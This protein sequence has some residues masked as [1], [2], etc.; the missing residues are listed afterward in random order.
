MST[1]FTTIKVVLR[2][3]G[4][5]AGDV[6]INP[7]MVT[8]MYLRF[9]LTKKGN[10]QKHIRIEFVKWIPHEGGYTLIPNQRAESLQ[11][12]AK[13]KIG[14]LHVGGYLS[15]EEIA[16]ETGL[17]LVRLQRD[18]ELTYRVLHAHNW[19]EDRKAPS[20]VMQR[21]LGLNNYRRGHQDEEE[22]MELNES[23]QSDLDAL[24]ER[25]E[26]RKIAEQVRNYQLS[27]F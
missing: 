21:L 16:A 1:P 7:A 25:I 17:L 14:A 5:F 9:P 6:V 18:I 12:K 10:F 20:T 3:V 4:D 24:I 19:I 8:F 23:E 26:A 13:Y 22:F 2:M 27:N 15:Q 11:E